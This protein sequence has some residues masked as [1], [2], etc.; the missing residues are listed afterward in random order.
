MRAVA[1]LVLNY[2]YQPIHITTWKRAIVLILKNK[3][4]VVEARSDKVLRT[5]RA[6]YPFPS[7]IRLMR[8][9]PVP[10]KHIPLTRENIFRRDGYR[11]AYCGAT[12]N[13]TIDHVIPRSQGGDDSWENL[14]TACEPCNHR[15][16]N[17][18]PQQAGMKL[19]VRPRRPHYLL[20]WLRGAEEIDTSWRPYLMLEVRA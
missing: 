14:V 7:I 2:D 17:R 16:G 3:A 11:C 4:E 19:L 20:F 6:E 9:V 12:H 5:V 13:L 15:K 18:T 10:Y 8:Y 1:V